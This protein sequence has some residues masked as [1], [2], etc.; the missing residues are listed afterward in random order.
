MESIADRASEILVRLGQP[1]VPLSEL[2][3]MIRESGAQVSEAVLLRSLNAEAGRFR[4]IQP[5]RAVR[6][7]GTDGDAT[8]T[9]D[10]W[11]LPAEP[12]KPTA[13]P[14]IRRLAASMRELGWKVDQA[15]APDTA[16]WFAM[17]LETERFRELTTA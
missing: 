6:R 5:W 14:A 17:V 12:V 16:R 4:V 15:S 2:G 11:V 3:R 8:T 7:S 9:G 1:A 10:T 13:R